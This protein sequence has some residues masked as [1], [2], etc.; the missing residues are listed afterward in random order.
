MRIMLSLDTLK[1]EEFCSPRIEI[2]FEFKIDS[3]YFKRVA[4][5][6]MLLYNSF[7]KIPNY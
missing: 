2:I 3:K 7:K 6:I 1:L 4:H 5:K